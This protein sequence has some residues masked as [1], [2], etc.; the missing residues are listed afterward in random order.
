MGG[1]QETAAHQQ[2]RQPSIGGDGIHRFVCL[3]G[4]LHTGE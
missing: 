4:E 1:K 2:H 3:K